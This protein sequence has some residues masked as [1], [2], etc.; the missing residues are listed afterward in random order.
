MLESDGDQREKY[1]LIFSPSPDISADVNDLLT[2]TILRENII[3]LLHW[4]VNYFLH[5][6]RDV[7]L[8]DEFLIS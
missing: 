6:K 8:H 3:E 7:H 5:R 4:F 1:H 2:D